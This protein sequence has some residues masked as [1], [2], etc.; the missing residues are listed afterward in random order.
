VITGAHAIIFT[1]DPERVRAFVFD[2]LGFASI[3][4]GGG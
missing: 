4:A 3:G 1:R 2:V